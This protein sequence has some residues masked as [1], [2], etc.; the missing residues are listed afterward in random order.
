MK[1]V[2]LPV[3]EASADIIGDVAQAG[4]V[5]LTVIASTLMDVELHGL[6]FTP[7]I[8]ACLIPPAETAPGGA[9]EEL[10]EYLPRGQWFEMND[11][12]F[13]AAVL[14]THLMSA[15]RRLSEVVHAMAERHRPG[16]SVVPLTDGTVTSVVEFEEDGQHHVWPARRFSQSWRSTYSKVTFG[17]LEEARPAPGV[18]AEIRAAELV[19]VPAGPEAE[20]STWPALRIPG[21]LEALRSTSGRILFVG[22]SPIPEAVR[23]ALAEADVDECYSWCLGCILDRVT[24]AVSRVLVP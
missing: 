10:A 14:R 17:G 6:R 13:A 21:M 16:Y 19:V 12:T 20:F 23:T 11:A 3:T 5:D 9:V 4:D 22:G 2:M 24:G 7:D 1:I 18:L 15:G 8:D